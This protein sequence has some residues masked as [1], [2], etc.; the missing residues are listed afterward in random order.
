MLKVLGRTFVL[1]LSVAAS[2]AMCAQ[3]SSVWQD[4]SNHHVQFVT[5]EEGI[6]LEVLDWGWEGASARVWRITR[7][8]SSQPI[9][10]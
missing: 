3:S 6:T 4:P 1:L 9:E 2:A 7:T 8:V 10:P 5:V